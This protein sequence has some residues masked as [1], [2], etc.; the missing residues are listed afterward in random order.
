MP[1]RCARNCASRVARRAAGARQT[2]RAARVDGAGAAAV[3]ASARVMSA[4]SGRARP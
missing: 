2:W 4:P 3:D 1:L